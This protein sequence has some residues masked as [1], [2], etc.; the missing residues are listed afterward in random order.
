MRFTALY[1]LAVGVLMTGQ[2]AFFLL[3]RQVPELQ[4]APVQTT[5][6]LAAELSTALALIL[7]GAGLLRRAAWARSLALLALG[8]LIYT[9]VQSPGYFAQQ[10]VWP[11]V[12]MFAVLLLLAFV[13]AIHLMRLAPHSSHSVT[14]ASDL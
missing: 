6:H 2:W 5:L 13:A 7:S 14:P 11:L 10:Q 3:S 1:L 9:L 8:M 12:A 4:T